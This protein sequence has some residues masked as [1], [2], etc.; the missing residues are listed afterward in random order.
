MQLWV[1][2]YLEACAQRGYA[3]N[4]QLAYQRD[5]EQF[6]AVLQRLGLPQQPLSVR[7]ITQYMKALRHDGVKTRS[8]LRKIS[9]LRSY[10][11]WLV[12]TQGLP[13]NPFALL[14]LPKNTH[15]LPK[16]LSMADV[17]ALLNDTTLSFS[18]RLLLELLYGCGLRISELLDLRVAD[19]N[20]QDGY[21]RCR[22]KGGKERLVP[23]SGPSIALV[24]T[25]IIMLDL[26]PTD[27]L[28]AENADKRL[29]TRRVLWGRV[30]ALGQRIGKDM[31]PHTLRHTFATHLLDG[32]ADLRV[33]QELLGHADIVTTQHY[34]H[35]SKA[36]AK[37]AYH[38]V[39]GPPP[40]V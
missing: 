5:L 11:H 3:S 10:H 33:V 40:E 31:S 12:Q 36:R 21:L 7:T 22:G 35:I 4:T 17:D 15:A 27:P 16:V 8:I 19:V 38:S 6:Y 2:E 18:D 13:S 23:L 14:E 20:V 34:T 26:Q 29:P 30:K 24:K 9:C 37:A 28:L 32:G 39:F 25:A 1:S